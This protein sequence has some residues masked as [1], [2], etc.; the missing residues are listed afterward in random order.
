MTKQS[1]AE[2]DA[3]DL[4]QYED[5][6]KNQTD[7]LPLALWRALVDLIKQRFRSNKQ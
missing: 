4:K 5:M 3:Q 2:R 7:S 1:D 6:V